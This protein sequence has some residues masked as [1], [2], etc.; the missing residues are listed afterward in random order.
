MTGNTVVGGNI[1]IN[2]QGA[3]TVA[4]PTII[5][6]N[7]LGPTAPSTTFLCGTVSG[8][9]ALNV[10]PKSHVDLQGGSATGSISPPCP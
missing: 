9:S 2:A 4:L 3:G 8:T 5:S 10:S 1:E 7:N 6:G